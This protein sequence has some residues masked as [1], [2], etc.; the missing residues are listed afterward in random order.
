MKNETQE[1][2]ESSSCEIYL[3]EGVE[4]MS[5]QVRISQYLS[6]QFH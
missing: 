6:F 3:D 5:K 4:E 1:K 2:E